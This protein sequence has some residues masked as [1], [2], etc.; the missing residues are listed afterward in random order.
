MMYLSFLLKEAKK[1][2]IALYNLKKFVD[3]FFFFTVIE[4]Q[5]MTY[6]LY[7]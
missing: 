4:K 1:Y 5:V 2:Y 6:V 7:F 3:Q